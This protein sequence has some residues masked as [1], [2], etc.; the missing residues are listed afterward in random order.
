MF[1]W[2]LSDDI[3]FCRP[4][5]AEP[6]GGIEVPETYQ[7]L[8]LNGRA[9]DVDEILF[10]GCHVVVKISTR[11]RAIKWVSSEF[12]IPKGWYSFIQLGIFACTKPP[13]GGMIMSPLRV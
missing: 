5:V 2:N 8:F 1:S 7:L 4:P 3:R 6:V 11:S 9:D 13:K 12:A 10:V